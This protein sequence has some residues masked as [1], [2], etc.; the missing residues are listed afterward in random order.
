VD[1]LAILIGRAK[2]GRI[3]HIIDGGASLLQ[4]AD[5]TIFYGSIFRKT[6]G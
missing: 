3:P 2:D 1:V 4:Y 5:D 6:P